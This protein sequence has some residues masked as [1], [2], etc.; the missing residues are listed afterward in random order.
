MTQPMALH[1]SADGKADFASVAQAVEAVR[2]RQA[3]IHVAPGRYREQIVLNRPGDVSIERAGGGVVTIE[4]E[5]TESVILR[6]GHL[7][8]RGLTLRREG[9]TGF[10]DGVLLVHAGHLTAERCTVASKAA[11]IVARASDAT[12]TVRE[13]R[14]GPCNWTGIL[15]TGGS[16]NL[17]G[18]AIVRCRTGLYVGGT[19][20][21]PHVTARRVEISDNH[22]FGIHLAGG[23][24]D[25]EELTVVVSGR[26]GI[27]VD[28]TGPDLATLHVRSSEISQNRGRGLEILGSRSSVSIQSSDIVANGD[29]G[30]RLVE[31]SRGEI[32]RC[33]LSAN[34]KVAVSVYGPGAWARI[35][36]NSIENGHDG[37]VIVCYGGR[38]AIL[39]NQ[40]ERNALAGIWVVHETS[41]A[42][43]EGNTLG[44]NRGQ[45]V[46]VVD[47]GRA[48]IRANQ[49]ERNHYPGVQVSG[50]GSHA[51]VTE[52]VI[53]DGDGVGVYFYG[54][55]GGLVERNT[56]TTN[57]A[58]DIQIEGE[59][60][61]PEIRSNR[62]STSGPV[63][64]RIYD[65]AAGTVSNNDLSGYSIAGIEVRDPGT[66]PIVRENSGTSDPIV[67]VLD[68]V[69]ATGGDT[70]VERGHGVSLG[71][72]PCRSYVGADGI[73]DDESV[74]ASLQTI[75]R[76][77]Q[78][79]KRLL[80]PLERPLGDAADRSGAVLDLP[81]RS[82]P[83]QTLLAWG[84]FNPGGP[85]SS[86]ID[87]VESG[88]E[89]ARL[90]VLANEHPFS[91][92]YA[93]FG[94]LD[95]EEDDDELRRELGRFFSTNGVE[96][97]RIMGSLPTYVQVIGGSPLDHGTAA[98]L[99]R[100]AAEAVEAA[101][102]SPHDYRAACEELLAFGEDPWGQASESLQRASRNPA[103]IALANEL[104]RM[105]DLP[106]LD[107]PASPSVEPTAKNTAL[108]DLWFALASAPNHVQAVASEMGQAWL[109]AQQLQIQNGTFEQLAGRTRVLAWP[110]LIG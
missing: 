85:T 101:T 3:T 40:I 94:I 58:P 76:S 52:N 97:A 103:V 54:G 19:I 57:R 22:E 75:A 110:G 89:D 60:T 105:D 39:Q 5:D 14:I 45:G 109:G 25:A 88:W 46:W 78:S 9:Q 73:P 41:A 56:V 92:S 62:L 34:G 4:T 18:S 98:A 53:A 51:E 42:T 11:G 93:A 38:A 72:L 1:V 108:F 35:Y 104:R 21:L 77:L 90:L 74:L 13:S 91:P 10:A 59:G 23:E 71:L 29:A 7:T 63:S 47:G 33:R 50:P 2:D 43:I 49:V 28:G 15:M 102:G 80:A 86:R 82:A 87:L 106:P 70:N 36:G 55:S 48:R 32:L 16:L 107:M 24:I 81:P 99:L 83:R 68:D 66:A 64:I 12:I 27:Y 95:A 30:V 8:L 6:E 69:V 67:A 100:A 84:W 20:G 37:G 26:D 79:D 96:Y 44:D 65:G 31:G 17:E 61:A